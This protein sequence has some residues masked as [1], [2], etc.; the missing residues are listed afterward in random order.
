[1]FGRLCLAL[2]TSLRSTYALE[3]TTELP[4]GDYKWFFLKDGQTTWVQAKNQYFVHFEL[5]KADIKVSN[6]EVV[7]VTKAYAIRGDSVGN[8]FSPRNKELD[9]CLLAGWCCVVLLFLFAAVFQW[10]AG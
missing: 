3:K 7:D 2:L 6:G 9:P 8:Y 10:L 1:M 4:E 5:S